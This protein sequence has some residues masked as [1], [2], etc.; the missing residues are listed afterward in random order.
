MPRLNPE[1]Q[2]IVDL[3]RKIFGDNWQS[4]FGRMTG[5]SKPYVNFIATGNRPVTQAVAVAVIEGLRAEVKRLNAQAAM[6]AGLSEK[7]E[8]AVLTKLLPGK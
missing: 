6:V 1:A 3:G 7:Y 4:A 2:R 8:A 5:L